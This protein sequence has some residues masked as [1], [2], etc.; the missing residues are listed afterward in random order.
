[1]K[2][3][4]S[5]ITFL[6]V[7]SPA[8]ATEP[9]LQQAP[10]KLVVQATIPRSG[11]SMAF[12]FE[13]LWMMSDSRLVRVNTTDNSVIDIELP[14][15]ES[16]A[17]L[18]EGDRYRGIAVGEGAVWVADI[19]SST[20]YKVDPH[21]NTVS[22][23]IP[24]DIFGSQGSIGVGEG[25]VW[26]VT[27]DDHDKTLTR[28][29]AASGAVEAKIPLPQ[30]SKGVLVEYGSVWVTAASRGELY[31]IDP[32]TNSVV[33]TTPIHA[34]S[35]LLASGDGS[36]WIPFQTEG[37]LQRVDGQSGD[38]IATIAT[39]ATDMESDGD[40]ATRGG[41]VWTITRGSIVARIDPKTNSAQGV[42]QPEA[43]LLMGRRIRYGAGSL[44]VSGNSIFR[45]GPPH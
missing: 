29:N 3:R 4:M 38:V 45:I 42:F 30:P 12:G 33:S 18:S 6:L 14:V 19:G 11:F 24:T 43:G 34:A 44:W 26:V 1:M 28:Y 22:I 41:F 13:S 10:E 37:V 31:R 8:W 35:H 23:K 20:I 16:A 5:L 25:A 17:A 2:A 36:I 27:F 40:I 39:G 21:S 32:K 9:V 15:S 7:A